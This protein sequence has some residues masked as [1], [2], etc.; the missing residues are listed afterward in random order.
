[1]RLCEAASRLLPIVQRHLVTAVEKVNGAKYDRLKAL[2]LRRALE[3]V[4][5][6]S[7]QLVKLMDFRGAET[8]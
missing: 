4:A 1:M 7:H 3:I 6:S 5:D 2:F 8:A